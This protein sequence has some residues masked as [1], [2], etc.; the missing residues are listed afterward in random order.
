MAGFIR[1]VINENDLDKIEVCLKEYH[2]T[3]LE[4]KLEEAIYDLSSYF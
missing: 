3:G 2:A 1:G 4:N